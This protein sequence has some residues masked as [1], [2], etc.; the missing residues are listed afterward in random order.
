MIIKTV[1]YKPNKRGIIVIKGFNPSLIEL[2]K[3]AGYKVRFV[4]DSL[5]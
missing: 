1:F 5:N 2:Y 3:A 4:Y